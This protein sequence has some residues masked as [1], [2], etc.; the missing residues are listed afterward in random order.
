MSLRFSSPRIVVICW[1]VL[2]AMAHA[3]QSAK[4]YPGTIMLFV[5]ASDAP[6]KLFRAKLMIPVAPGPLTLHY[7]KWIP[8][9][10][11]PT[12][13]INSLTGLKVTAGGQ[14]LQWRRDDVDTYAFH[15][16]VPAGAKELE[17][18]LDYASPSE[19]GGFT[20]GATASAHMMVLSWNW[21]LLYPQGYEADQIFY[22]ASLRLPAGWQSGS[23]LPVA[24]RSG[25][26]VD[27]QSASL[28]TLIDSPV[29]AGRYFR[30]LPLT[31][32]GAKP[33]VEL[34]IAADSAAALEMSPQLEQHF[35][36][37][38]AEATGLFGA[39]HYRD[40]HFLLS[41]SDHVAHFGLEHH[42][43]NDSRTR[44]RSLVNPELTLLMAALLPH[45]YTHS[46]NGKYRRPQGLTT[47]DYSEAM[48]GELLWVYEG[49]TDYLGEILS[50]RSGLR[51]PQ[52]FRDALAMTAAQM[53]HH[54]GR[55]WR[56]LIDTAIDAQDLYDSPPDWKNW[57]RSVDFYQE[58]DLVWL[59][60]DMTI[61]RSTGGKRSLDDF[62]KL[63][64]GPPSLPLDQV[65]AAR[66]YD[67]N[68]ILT[69]LNQVAPYD[70]R[71]FWDDRLWSTS[72]HAPLAGIEA[73]GWRVVFNE[74][75][76]ELM[77][78]SEEADRTMDLTYSLGIVLENSDGRIQDV[79]MDS[80]A[81]KA[82]IGPGMKLVAVNGRAWNSEVLRDALSAAKT[83]S[84]PLQLLIENS[85]F[86]KTYAV[87]Y[88][89]GN[90]YPHL[91]RSDDGP[92]VLSEIIKQHSETR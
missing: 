73:G 35:R 62:C 44:E 3:Q 65:P 5:D 34:D 30:A 83:A 13:P 23:A 90:R 69:L 79:A 27:Y 17:V 58:G 43:S 38:V 91:V 22:R 53:E 14:V 50:A 80:P 81:A 78:A 48:K 54:S 32:P 9:E 59:D 24:S 10:H 82:G 36:Q 28:Y 72:P 76:S 18:A 12:G 21:L 26:T 46:W 51:T 19:R 88:H 84:E 1:V 45:E 40:Y 11:G 86:F 15:V 2:A 63:F 77:R 57:R 25:N 92:D 4:Q 8:G 87:D 16:L 89:G 56:P 71:K 74:N 55:T 33:A 61:R 66:S 29:I 64:A 20:A 60:A 68:E 37:L 70:W 39:T 41:L 49:L 52:Q 42:E 75:P 67:F 31:S 6:A 85:D 7:P 47:P